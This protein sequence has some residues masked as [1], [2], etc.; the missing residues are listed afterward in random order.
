MLLFKTISNGCLCSDHIFLPVF[1]YLNIPTLKMEAKLP[2][3][4]PFILVVL[5][6]NTEN[7]KGC[8]RAVTERVDC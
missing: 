3:V 8:I 4:A 2:D 7:L 1:I 6:M 5:K